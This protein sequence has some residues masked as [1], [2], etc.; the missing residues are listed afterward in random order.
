MGISVM[1]SGLSK[2]VYVDILLK[3]NLE[4][5]ERKTKGIWVSILRRYCFINLS[6]I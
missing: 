3:E 1:W 5:G 2:A 6:Y 4:V